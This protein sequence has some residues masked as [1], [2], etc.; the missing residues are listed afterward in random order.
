MFK[1]GKLLVISCLFTTLLVACNSSNN[2]NSG[3]ADP[4]GNLNPALAYNLPGDIPSNN[5]SEIDQYSW[6]TFLALNAPAVGERVSLTGD[7]TTQYSAW[8]SSND[9]IRCNLDDTDC[10]CP[11]GDCSNSGA[12][13]YPPECQEV[14][15]YTAYRVL[16]NSNKADDSFLEATTGGLSDQPVLTSQGSFLR[17]EI[18]INPAFYNHVVENRYYDWNYLYNTLDQ[19]VANL[20]GEESYTGGDPADPRSGTYEVKLAWMEQGLADASYHREDIL[21][22]TPAYR[23]STSTASCELKSMAMV[24]THIAHKTQKQPS[25][26]WSTFEHKDNAPD[27]EGLPPAGNQMGASV[28]EACPDA[29]TLTRNYHFTS[30]ECADGSCGTCNM[31]PD[32]NDPT[33]LCA[34]STDPTEAGWC[35]D[36]PP[37]TVA[38]KSQLCRQVPIEA[39]YPTAYAQNN[40]YAELLGDESVWSNYQLISTQW[41]DFETP[42]VGCANAAPEFASNSSRTLQRPQVAVTSPEGSTR[43]LL[44]NSSMES[45]ERSNCNAC[46]SKSTIT[47]ASGK[48]LNADFVYWIPV[49]SC[50]IWCDLNAVSPCTCLQ[51][52]GNVIGG[53]GGGGGGG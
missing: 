46:H 50:A 12:R 51:G 8:S 10:V 42:Q 1:L 31:P 28:N 34:T 20:C 47:Q 19:D 26:T 13:Y 40:T 3:N 22:F 33:G 5:Q 49:E 21:V 39:N 15:N 30:P 43:P 27:C 37:A 41:F 32:T 6:Q 14:E 52:G 29:S 24:G 17:Y 23:S 4:G 2:N 36:Q 18:L 7:N 45:Y 11:D 44:G 9:L 53:G 25:W 35:L 38:G 48:V 16:D